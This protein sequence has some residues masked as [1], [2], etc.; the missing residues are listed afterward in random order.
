MVK[1]DEIKPTT[2]AKLLG[3]VSKNIVKSMHYLGFVAP[4][5]K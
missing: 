4:F 1:P 3:H 5:S 2:S